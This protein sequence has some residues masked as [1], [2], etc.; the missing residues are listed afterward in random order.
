MAIKR[1]IA[2]Q[3]AGI[4]RRDTLN[5]ESNAMQEEENHTV[6]VLRQMGILLPHL[7]CLLG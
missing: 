6:V 5:E 2:N 7:S 4:H 3:S 1:G